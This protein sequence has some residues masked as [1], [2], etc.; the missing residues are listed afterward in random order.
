ME[1]QDPV[2]SSP[3]EV[4]VRMHAG[5]ICGSDMHCYHGTSAFARYPL[6]PGHEVSAELIELGSAVH[7]LEIGDHMVLDPVNSCGKCYSN[8]TFRETEKCRQEILIKYA[9]S[10]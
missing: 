5:G 8:F 6:I 9:T 2:I 4:L 3:D 7:D 10:G 1:M